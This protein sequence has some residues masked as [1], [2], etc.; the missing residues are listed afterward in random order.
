MNKLFIGVGL[1]LCAA[2]ASQ[3]AGTE[4]F[5]K[6][7]DKPPTSGRTYTKSTWTAS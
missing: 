4:K 1:M 7:W 5:Y 3:Q 6:D 2:C